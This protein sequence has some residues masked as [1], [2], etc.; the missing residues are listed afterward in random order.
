MSSAP[1][2]STD[3]SQQHRCQ[4]PGCKGILRSEESRARGMSV[5]CERRVRQAEAIVENSGAFK[6]EQL[7]KARAAIRS[8]EVRMVEPGLYSVPSSKNDGSDYGT[9]AS[10][11]PC[12]AGAHDRKCWHLAVAITLDLAS[13]RRSSL[14]KAA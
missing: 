8:G 1:M 12:P 4:R 5:L 14:A 9:A 13:V 7:D 3:T 11:C 10:G 2:T 6:P